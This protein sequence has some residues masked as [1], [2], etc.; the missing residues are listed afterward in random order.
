[1][2]PPVHTRRD[3]RD[4]VEQMRMITRTYA[5][6]DRLDDRLLLRQCFLDD[7]LHTFAS[8]FPKSAQ[9]LEK[10]FRRII[11][12]IREGVHPCSVPFRD[13]PLI[14]LP[15]DTLPRTRYQAPN[16]VEGWDHWV[17]SSANLLSQEP[18]LL[19]TSSFAEMNA[20][21]STSPLQPSEATAPSTLIALQ[22]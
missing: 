11:A 5:L 20:A 10:Y 19:D 21:N 2:Q 1:M 3:L 15:A 13:G 8:R 16:F 14:S 7:F 18:F 22:T 6:N 12:A 4:L 9:L 17:C